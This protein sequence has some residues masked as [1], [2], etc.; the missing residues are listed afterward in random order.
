MVRGR[1]LDGQMDGCGGVAMLVGGWVVGVRKW[2]A[3]WG[4][5]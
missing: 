3:S 4:G 2:G 5:C 1:W